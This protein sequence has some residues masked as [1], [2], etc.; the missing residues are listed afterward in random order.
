MP[1][2]GMAGVTG[3]QGD[4]PLRQRAPRLRLVA[5][6]ASAEPALDPSQQ[7]ALDALSTPGGP[8]VVTG[9][10][11][12]G[13]TTVVVAAAARAVADGT[14]AD[15]VLVI[16]PT[17]QAAAA[18]RDRVATAIGAP[19]GSPVVRTAASVAF[20]VLRAEADALEE[21]R[22]ALVSGA[23]QDVVLRELLEGHDSGRVAPLDWGEAV[24]QEATTLPGFREELRNLLM[25]A[26]ERGVEPDRLA[27]LGRAAGRPE[28]EAAAA[29]Y[30]EY[31]SVMALRSTPL[32]QGGR[33]DPATILSRATQALE[34][35]DS[36]VGSAVPQ[37]SWDLVIVD[38]A[39]DATAAVHDLIAR[40][41]SD[42]A[43]VVLV[44]NADE[45]VQGYRGAVPER[46]AE[47]LAGDGGVHVELTHDHR[48]GTLTVVSAQIAER[49]GV[50][51]PASA[52][53]AY[54]D[55]RTENRAG[56]PRSAPVQSI[57]APHRYA[58]SR[59]IAAALR[60]ARH[61]L[62][63]PATG[64]RDMAVVARSG[65]QLRA[66]RS[67][68]LA[69]DIPCEPLGDGTALHRE[70]AV[71]PLLTLLKVAFG[72][73]WDEDSVV[74]VLTSRLVGLDAVGLRRLRR[75]LVRDERQGGGSRTSAELLIDAMG[76]P[77]RCA[78]L[79]GPEPR[80]ASRA[81]RAVVAA[82]ERAQAPAPTP[83]AVVWAAWEALDVAESWRAAALAGS[84]RD[85][86]DLDAVIALMRA[87]QGFTERLPEAPAVAFLDYLEAQ[88]FAADSLGLRGR[89]PDA[90]SFCTPASAAGREWDVVVVAGL[91]E[92]V[93]PNLRL[94][95]SVLGAQA[96]ADLVAAGGLGASPD[97][98]LAAARGPRDL[99][100]A[101][102]SVLDDE[103]RALLV[104]VSRA[105]TRLIVTA[106]DDGEA[107]PSR[108][109]ALIEDAA[110]VT[111]EDA[112][113]TRVVSDLRSAVARLRSRGAAAAARLEHDPAD[114]RALA[115]LE[116]AAAQLA[117]LSARGIAGADPSRWHG[118]P[119][120][121]T[122]APFWDEDVPVRVSPS[123][124][125]AVRTCALRWALES[126]GG[127]PESSDAQQVGL[128][129]HEIAA[130]FPDGGEER[131]LAELESR[132]SDIG[133]QETWVEREDY[134]RAQ[135]MVR[136]LAAYLDA[137]GAD[138]VLV[139]E[140]FSV[141]LGRAQVAGIADRVEVSGSE[142][143][144]VDLKT[145]AK[146]SRAEAAD[147]GQLLL[148]QLVAAHGAFAGVERA[149]DAA[150]VFVGKDAARAG[151]VVEQGA[152]D[153]E[154]AREVLDAAVETMTASTFTATT[155]PLCER[156]PV[157]RACPA[158]ASG[159]QVSD[160]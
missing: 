39:Q 117:D 126:S 145:G 160:S 59:A 111:R 124:L 134:A 61:G 129:V 99:R 105:R 128:L 53:R 131:M 23:E 80:A 138:D 119:E 154:A 20:A 100:G 156:C 44:G 40:L 29:L 57:T 125:D 11:G 92:G 6:P 91:E 55:L 140:G 2:G 97:A 143:R 139:E 158:H 58:Q 67:D 77:A 1:H 120:P 103:T 112:A 27:D 95:D 62:E 150:L 36:T 147:H 52:R 5:P 7:R 60:R 118:V 50:K 42:G 47:P 43:R 130:Q 35:W 121:S 64:W 33:Y 81:A 79:P 104:A 54:R 144:I 16:A 87:A 149:S 17:R 98:A 90:V 31:E 137:A 14:P 12:T 115:D 22:P 141:T 63:G 21:P 94:R 48:Q 86:A 75:A 136:R 51:G 56:A 148:Y 37:P 152:I 157:R 102:A 49:I 84:A 76:D 110:G 132:W 146:I 108:F 153:P 8:V 24:P 28:W 72:E 133:G 89:A 82:R 85:D 68:L 26:A 142:A 151:S 114:A 127:T 123:R 25:R 13:K 113:L 10:P 9:A 73:P 74:E 41:A 96:F 109:L 34:W 107:R 19:T 71:A 101:R 15:R 155:N 69:A 65:A 32:D 70:S 30:E 122:D 46:L 106:V 18:L 83:G 88:D 135:A 78:G 93:W 45:S 4:R 116:G 38:D 159:R 3:E 66:L